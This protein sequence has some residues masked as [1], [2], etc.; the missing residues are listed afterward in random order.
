MYTVYSVQCTASLNVSNAYA[1]KNIR[2]KCESLK[3]IMKIINKI[4]S[5]FSVILNFKHPSLQ[6]QV[7]DQIY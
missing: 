2:K 3:V 6:Q 7:Q 4:K 5:G 1:K